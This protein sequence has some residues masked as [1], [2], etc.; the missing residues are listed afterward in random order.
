MTTY[1]RPDLMK[2]RLA[3]MAR[4]VSSERVPAALSSLLLRAVRSRALWTFLA[5]V[6]TSSSRRTNVR[7]LVLWLIS[8]VALVPGTLLWVR[9]GGCRVLPV[10]A[11][12]GLW[13]LGHFLGTFGLWAW[14]LWE[15]VTR[16]KRALHE[17][18]RACKL[19]LRRDLDALLGVY[20]CVRA[21]LRAALASHPALGP[22][23]GRS[24]FDARPRAIRP[25]VQIAAP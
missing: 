13:Q 11:W 24:R 12:L 21:V 16:L 4:L 8:V 1:R 19:A 3:Q 17:A 18:I 6:S 22:P 15:T 25:W 14:E 23:E 2:A 20:E 7:L 9:C 10:C 5:V